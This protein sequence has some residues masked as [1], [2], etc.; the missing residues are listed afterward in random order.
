MNC[1]CLLE[2]RFGLVGVHRKTGQLVVPVAL[3]DAEIE[4]PAGQ[5]VEG[6]GLFG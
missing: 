5:E 2:T 3:A 1:Q 6:R 4:P